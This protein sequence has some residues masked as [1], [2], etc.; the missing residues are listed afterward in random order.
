MLDSLKK[1][2]L[3][4]LGAVAFSH[5]KLK[6]IIDELIAKG[7]LT[8]EQGKKLL[9]TLISRGREEGEE[10][11]TKFF[12]ELQSIR[13]LFPITKREMQKLVERVEKLEALV[14]SREA[15]AKAA[16]PVTASPLPFE[17]PGEALPP[18]PA[19]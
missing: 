5:D 7:E 6:Q 1:T 18:R 14:L 12:A 11:S 9:D 2:F 8:R 3:A 4:S 17:N 19:E 13:D 10:I 15:A 16:A